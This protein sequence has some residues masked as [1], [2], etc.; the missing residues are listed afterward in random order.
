MS[1]WLN[2]GTFMGGFG[3][4]LAAALALWQVVRP[5]PIDT[6]DAVVAALNDIRDAIEGETIPTRA[7]WQTAVGPDGT[8]T[9]THVGIPRDA[10]D[11]A[12]FRLAC[13]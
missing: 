3:G 6:V 9:L 8:C 13:P 4:A 7:G 11:S 12:R 1:R 10:P 2:A 5:G